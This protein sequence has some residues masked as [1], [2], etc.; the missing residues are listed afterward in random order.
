MD[1]NTNTPKTATINPKI[2]AGALVA[3]TSVGALVLIKR[4]LNVPVVEVAVDTK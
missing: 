3:F 1:V 2:V 4:K